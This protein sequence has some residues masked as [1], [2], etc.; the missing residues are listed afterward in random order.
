MFAWILKST[1]ISVIFIFLIH[2]LI[3]FFKNMLTTPKI[4]DFVTRPTQKYEKMLN[5][6]HHNDESTSSGTTN[7][8]DLPKKETNMKEELK[9]YLK[10]HLKGDDEPES[11][12]FSS[13]S[14]F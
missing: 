11:F 9:Q 1:I 2:H 4:K 7:L 6:I 8:E 14:L 13:S 10:T 5:A 12:D 3:K